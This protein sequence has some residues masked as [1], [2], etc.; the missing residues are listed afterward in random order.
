MGEK[1][2]KK[3]HLAVILAILLLVLVLWPIWGNVTVGVNHYSITRNQLPDSFDSFKIAVVSD[4]HNARFGS[5]NSQIIRKIEE[6]HPDIIAI[7]GDLVDSN[8]TDMET[9]IAL[10]HK[11]MQIAPCYYVTGNHEAWIGKQFSELEEMLLAENVQ[12]LHDEVIRLEK[13]AK[14]YSLLDWMIRI[15]Q[16][17]ILPFSKVC[18]KQS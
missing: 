11:L 12:I 9:A 7:T 16:K 14:R 3:K 1:N 5:D 4:L 2:D 8:R 13:K 6:E 15:L 17:G 10:V 18:F